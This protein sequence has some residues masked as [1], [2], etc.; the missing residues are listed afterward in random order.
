M[1]AVSRYK[2]AVITAPAK[3]G[4]CLSRRLGA[5]VARYTH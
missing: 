4:F 5:A 2:N 3:G 1:R